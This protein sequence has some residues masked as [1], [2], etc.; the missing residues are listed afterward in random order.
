MWP[1]LYEFIFLAPNKNDRIIYLASF[2]VC[3]RFCLSLLRSFFCSSFS[4]IIS[5]FSP[6]RASL[7]TTPPPLLVSILHTPPTLFLS[8]F[9]SLFLPCH[10]PSSIV[11]RFPYF[12]HRNSFVPHTETIVA[13]C[14]I[15]YEI[16]D[17]HIQFME[18]IVWVFECGHLR[19]RINWV[20]IAENAV[21]ING[22]E[23]YVIRILRS[24]PQSCCAIYDFGKIC[25]HIENKTLTLFNNLCGIHTWT[26]MCATAVLWKVKRIMLTFCTH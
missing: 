22:I 21:P 15:F 9:F 18:R 1:A 16:W 17:I 19:R 5:L 12:N 6:S 14:E 26:W 3:F 7:R 20:T 24:I 23:I 13:N 25:I 4:I 10:P 8:Q 2:F 11:H